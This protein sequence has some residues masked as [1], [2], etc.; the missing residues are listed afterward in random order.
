LDVINQV[1]EMKKQV[2]VQ[3]YEVE[4]SHR[5]LQPRRM[6]MHLTTLSYPGSYL[7]AYSRMDITFFRLNLMKSVFRVTPK[8]KR[9]C[10]WYGHSNPGCEA[11]P[12]PTGDRTE[13]EGP[14]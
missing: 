1:H 8:T 5:F 9:T 11:N 10:S 3:K 13:V 2:E 6:K 4:S 7:V 12:A 14:I